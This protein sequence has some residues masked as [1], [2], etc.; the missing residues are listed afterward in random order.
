VEVEAQDAAVGVVADDRGGLV[1]V[2]V[3][4]VADRV[5]L[6]V[7]PLE[8]LAAALVTDLGLGCGELHLRNH[9]RS[10]VL[11][12]DPAGCR[13]DGHLGRRNDG[14]G[15]MGA[16][17]LAPAARPASARL[18]L[19]QELLRF[20]AVGAT[21]TVLHLGIFAVAHVR[22]GAQVANLVALLLATVFNTAAN[23]CWTFGVRGYRGIARHH[24]QSLAVFAIT[25]A[26]TGAALALLAAL[27]PAASTV[28]SLLAVA[29][30][31]ALST[32][33]R[34]VVMRQWI[35]RADLGG[36]PTGIRTGVGADGR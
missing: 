24:V 1:G 31:T 8:Q 25:W 3:Q 34:F 29:A 22:L 19:R 27:R 7:V 2:H 35:F 9:R 17:T 23:R 20:A 12:P 10:H 36:E 6:V 18:R 15:L 28:T 21:S 16:M 26:V 30:A 33:L 32:G 4:P 5:L 13:L 14:D 11:R